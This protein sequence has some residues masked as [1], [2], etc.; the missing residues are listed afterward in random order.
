LTR[1]GGI[2]GRLVIVVFNMSPIAE[3]P[4]RV[5]RTSLIINYDNTDYDEEQLG[6]PKVNL[7]PGDLNRPLGLET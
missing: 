2:P 7:E 6:T 3:F 5:N 4:P 1:R